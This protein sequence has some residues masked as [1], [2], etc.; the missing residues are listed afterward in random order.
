MVN[1]HGW[2]S[3]DT[4]T[5]GATWQNISATSVENLIKNNPK[6][7][8]RC[9]GSGLVEVDN[10]TYVL[11]KTSSFYTAVYAK[12]SESEFVIKESI[13]GIPVNGI[14][15]GTFSGYDNIVSIEGQLTSYHLSYLQFQ[16]G[17]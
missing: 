3:F 17:V 2:Q 16:H 11:D 8:Y 5:E 9:D 13:S 1:T 6:L 10:I 15:A 7:N 12:P 14:Y 4:D